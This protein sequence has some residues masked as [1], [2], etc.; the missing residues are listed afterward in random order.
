MTEEDAVTLKRYFKERSRVKL[1]AENPSYNPIYAQGVRI[2]GK[3]VSVYRR[4]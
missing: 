2:L 4:Y 1:Q 3:L